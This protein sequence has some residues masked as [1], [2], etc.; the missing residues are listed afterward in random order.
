MSVPGVSVI[1]R[2][3]DRVRLLVDGDLVSA[4]ALQIPQIEVLAQV[5]L[6]L[7]ELFLALIK[8]ANGGSGWWPQM[9]AA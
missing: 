2:Q 1:D 4:D 7:E 6:T 9:S 5:P 3:G 8:G